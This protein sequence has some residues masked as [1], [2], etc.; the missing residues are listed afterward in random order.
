MHWPGY[1]PGYV[2][3]DTGR[4]HGWLH[5]QDRAGTAVGHKLYVLDIGAN[6]SLVWV[7]GSMFSALGIEEFGDARLGSECEFTESL[8]RTG[9]HESRSGAEFPSFRLVIV[10]GS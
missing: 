6:D 8:T 7:P 4:R 5:R 3:T 10:P 9:Q 1:V 2:V